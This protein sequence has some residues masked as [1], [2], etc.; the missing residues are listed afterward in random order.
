MA[1]ASR[2]TPQISVSTLF[3]IAWK[4]CVAAQRRGYGCF[5]W[6]Y[7][8]ERKRRRVILPALVAETK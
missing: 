2:N 6:L 4:V 7:I 8:I 3:L 1:K 5:A